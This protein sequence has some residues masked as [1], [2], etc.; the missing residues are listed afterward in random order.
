MGGE[1]ELPTIKEYN[2]WLVDY[3]IE[4]GYKIVYIKYP[5][6]EM[7]DWNSIQYALDEI[8][9]ELSV[10]R[11]ALDASNKRRYV[12]AKELAEAR[13]KIKELLTEH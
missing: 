11:E 7:R 3:K 13:M 5:D 10:C 2:K 8:S 9:K 12:L 1:A 6:L 4:D